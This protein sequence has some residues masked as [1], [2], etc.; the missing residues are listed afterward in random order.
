MAFPVNE[1]GKRKG[2][3]FFLDVS[4]ECAVEAAKAWGMELDYSSGSIESVEALAQKIYLANSMFSLP[5]D[6]LGG[7]ANLYG[8][9]LGEVLLRCGLKDLDFAW[10][11]NEEGEIG[12]GDDDMWAAPVNKVYKRITQG[13]YHDLT[14]FFEVVFGMAIGA[15]DMN[16]PRMHVLSEGEAV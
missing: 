11:K 10:V 2:T 1:Q 14:D 4:A 15:V 13:P 6:F 9:Y 16:D 3:S 8:A 12:I 5:E 7:V